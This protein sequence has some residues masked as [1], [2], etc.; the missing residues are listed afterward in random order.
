M[1]GQAQDSTLFGR[2]DECRV[3]DGLLA[4]AEAGASGVL[5]I[6]GEAGIGKSVLLAYARDR[7]DGMTVLTARGVEAESELA[8]A[9]STSFSARS[10]TG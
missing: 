8:F 6:H 2:D 10:S 5:A 7:A 9:T 4:D 3:I 1:V